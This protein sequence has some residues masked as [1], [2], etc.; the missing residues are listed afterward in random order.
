MRRFIV[1]LA[2]VLTA[3]VALST[4]PGEAQSPSIVV[5]P[6]SGTQDDI[7]TFTGAG[8]VPGTTIEETYISPDGEQFTFYIEGVPAVIVVGDDGGF[9]VTV[10]P[11][12]DF[13]GA[14]A[15]VWRVLFCIS[16]T[17]ECWYG[18]IEI[19]A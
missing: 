18:D 1:L 4:T 14:R 15:G 17:A 6:V 13:A 10:Y 8:F 16:G 7:F 12:R 11:R 9:I 5:A 19:S 2:A 3:T